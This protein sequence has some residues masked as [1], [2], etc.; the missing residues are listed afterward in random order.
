MPRDYM[1]RFREENR[2]PIDKMAKKLHISPLLLSMLED[3]ESC[4]THPLIAKRV[5]RAYKL[6]KEQRTM[7]LPE[8]YRPGPDYD[9][10]R[11]KLDAEGKDMYREFKI[12]P[13]GACY[14]R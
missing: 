6:T 4:V 2:I 13:R 3:D 7:M 9:P 11:Y 14:R 12:A 10:N 8:N 5:A 1:I